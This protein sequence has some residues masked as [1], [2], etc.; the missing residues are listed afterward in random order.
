MRVTVKLFAHFRDSRFKTENRDI[1][2]GTTVGDIV[3]SL[4]IVREEVGVLM[5]NSRHAEFDSSLSED[6]TL[7]IFPMIGGG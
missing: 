1:P 7:A 3:D 2:D 5:I 4:G 6:C